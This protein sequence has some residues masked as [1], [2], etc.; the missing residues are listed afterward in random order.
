M[1]L[2]VCKFVYH[3]STYVR[4]TRIETGASDLLAIERG[5][6]VRFCGI[7]RFSGYAQLRGDIRDRKIAYVLREVNAPN[8][9]RYR[10]RK[11]VCLPGFEGHLTHMRV[12]REVS[13]WSV[14]REVAL[15][16]SRAA[17]PR[18]KELPASRGRVRKHAGNA[19]NGGDSAHRRYK[20]ARKALADQS[21]S[22]RSGARIAN[23]FFSEK[24]SFFFFSKPD[25]P[26]CLSRTT[27]LSSRRWP[28]LL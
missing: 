6:C 1:A 24:S 10:P 17:V 3:Q 22:D 8:P 9:G 7:R 15:S 20:S 21:R 19:G 26:N 12:P 5:N 16:V 27:S 13:T 25:L 11:G 18:S 2:N 28:S 4:K 23:K 14:P